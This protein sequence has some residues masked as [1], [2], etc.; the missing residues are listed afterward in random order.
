MVVIFEV[1]KAEVARQRKL[2]HITNKDIGKMTGYSKNTIDLFMTSSKSRED[3]EN[4][5]KAIAHALEIEI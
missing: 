2:R 4:V 3:S 5:A 1:F